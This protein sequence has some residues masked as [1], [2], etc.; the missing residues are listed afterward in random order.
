MTSLSRS[1][2]QQV[3]SLYPEPFRREFGKEMLGVFDECW[4]AQRRPSLLLDGF[5]AALKQQLHYLATPA[6]HTTALYCE[7]PSSPILPRGLVMAVLATVL[8]SGVLLPS[9]K[10][11]TPSWPTIRAEHQIWYFQRATVN[12]PKLAGWAPRKHE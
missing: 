1:L 5:V 3:I 7:V 8:F 6:P 11:R 2:Y 12:R 4:A 10:A 9:A